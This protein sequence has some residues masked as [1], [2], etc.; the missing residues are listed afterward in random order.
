MSLIDRRPSARG[1]RG[2]SRGPQVLL[3]LDHRAAEVNIDA[4]TIP[5]LRLQLHVEIMLGQAEPPAQQ[6]LADVG[7]HR[8]LA[9]YPISIRQ[10][11]Q[12]VIGVRHGWCL[13]R[14][15]PTV[16][17]YLA[18]LLRVRVPVHG[19]RA[20]LGHREAALPLREGVAALPRLPRNRLENPHRPAPIQRDHQ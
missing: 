16:A 15:D 1:D 3:D 17:G 19:L 12:Q 7:L 20:V 8:R 14:A 5:Q 4:A 2:E 13:P 9:T 6:Q 18:R 11:P 10:A